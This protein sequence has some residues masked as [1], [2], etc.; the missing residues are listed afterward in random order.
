MPFKIFYDWKQD[1]QPLELG[2]AVKIF[3]Q[4][5]SAKNL[6]YNFRRF[7]TWGHAI[8]P[9]QHQATFFK[10]EI[11]Y[12]FGIS[13]GSRSGGVKGSLALARIFCLSVFAFN[14][15]YVSDGPVFIPWTFISAPGRTR[16]LY[17]VNYKAGLWLK[18]VSSR[19]LF[20]VLFHS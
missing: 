8:S 4:T 13:G 19:T 10:E 12:F 14:T 2:G 18:N 5:K 9:W 16:C 6:P 11:N 17:F 20:Y 7:W 1:I 15:A 3:S